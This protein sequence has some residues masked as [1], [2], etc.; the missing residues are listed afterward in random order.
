MF[1]M[2]RVRVEQVHWAKDRDLRSY[3]ILNRE[4]AEIISS[5]TGSLQSGLQSRRTNLQKHQ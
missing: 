5:T 1:Y 2:F 4:V 3:D